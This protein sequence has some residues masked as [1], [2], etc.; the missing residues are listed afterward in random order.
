MISWLLYRE[1]LLNSTHN[2][3]GRDDITQP[4]IIRIKLLR[5]R[6][7]VH[8]T[9]CNHFS[10]LHGKHTKQ[11]RSPRF[12]YSL[13]I[14]I[15]KDI[16]MVNCV[17]VYCAQD[18]ITFT[19]E[20]VFSLG[21]QNAEHLRSIHNLWMNVTHTIAM[22]LYFDALFFLSPV[23]GVSKRCVELLCRVKL[24]FSRSRDI[25]MHTLY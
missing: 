1:S 13:N 7:C 6:A 25:R 16:S 4:L 18:R 11:I 10:L 8:E 22:K 5:L 21:K 2:F 23:H 15:A 17:C 12:P 14:H 9:A 19:A 3:A 20:M 24:T